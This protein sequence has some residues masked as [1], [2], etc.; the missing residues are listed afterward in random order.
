MYSQDEIRILS[1]NELNTITAPS[2][3]SVLENFF[4]KFT[5][6]KRT[7]SNTPPFENSVPVIKKKPNYIYNTPQASKGRAISSDD[8]LNLHLEL[9]QCEDVLQFIEKI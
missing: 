5:K 9:A 4:D 8:V 2:T 1:E 3:E 7:K 6:K